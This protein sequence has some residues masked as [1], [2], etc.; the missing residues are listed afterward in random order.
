M[1]CRHLLVS[2]VKTIL[3]LGLIAASQPA[4]AD[5]PVTFME[6][7]PTAGV[8]Y[9][10]GYNM[11]TQ[12]FTSPCLSYNSSATYSSGDP[13]QGSAFEFAENTATIA[14]KSNLTVSASLK[15]L[16]GGGTYKAN[17]KTSVA[18][19]T[20]SSTYSQSLFAN[21]YRYDVPEFLDLGQV[22]F[23]SGPLQLLSTPGG[24]GQFRQQCG[25][26][27]VIGIQKGREFVGTA[28]VTQ[29]SLKSWTKFSNE[30]G[31]S[32]SGLWGSVEAG[33]NIGEEM[34]QAFGS[35]NISVNTYSTGSDQANPT[36]A[37]EL[38]DYFQKFLNSSGPEKMIKVVVAPYNLVEN[39]PWESP[40]KENTKDDYIGMMV[41]SLWELRA[42]INDADFILN[43][44]TKNMFALGLNAGVKAQRVN[45]IKQQKEVWQNEYDMLLKAALK[46]DKDF[47][48]QCQ[49]LAEFY[50]RHRNLAAQWY[51]VLPERYLSD[52]YQPLI[53]KDFSNLKNDLVSRN[54][55]TPVS[56][57]S[58]TSG[59]KGRVVAE[60]TFRKDQRQLKADLSVAKIQWKSKEW[61]NQPIQV[62]AKKGESGWGLKSQAIVFDL[63][64]PQQYG[65]GQENLKSC[66]WLGE[67]VQI[68][69]IATPPA[70]NYFHR[71]GFS[72]RKTNGYIDGVTG[73][74]P[75]GQQMFANGLGALDFI[76]C[77]VDR[78][79][80]DNNMQC[81]DLGVR[82]VR[83][84]LCSQQD[85][86]ADQWRQPA[87]PQVPTALANFS[88]NRPVA[89]AQNAQQY[90]ALTAFVP[91]TQRGQV[92]RID[93]NKASATGKFK[94]TRFNLPAKQL[95][96]MKTR[97]Q[98]K[99]VSP[100]NMQPKKMLKK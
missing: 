18:G 43:P 40:L 7:E 70:A 71:F 90:K 41:V 28:T 98:L 48:G 58:E 36:K 61:K 14:A 87:A 75:R 89:L 39:Y 4:I 72:Q 11:T 33:V 6:L 38:K 17:N 26:G 66:T 92:A 56:G 82:N 64:K 51:A 85:L 27:F 59:S 30:T 81:L 15:V 47:T 79:G 12:Q 3:V 20:E 53:L 2:V 54:L 29:Q 67:G 13:D 21:A 34:E 62:N 86:A 25:D 10:W 49:E 55:G 42:A 73:D 8:F 88:N 100:N 45:Y 80:K 9:G 60:L 19:G 94:A 77:E 99:T 52:C 97:L 95:N 23:K 32:A 76:T 83:L 50:D 1:D 44:T 96:L 93:A 35:N 22:T 5:M 37:G 31:A 46:C 57:D 69:N 65:L 91:A 16:A 74:N 84:T 68:I 63:D 78:K 24:N